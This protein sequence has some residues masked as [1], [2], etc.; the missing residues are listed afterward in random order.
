MFYSEHTYSK[1]QRG[2]SKHRQIVQIISLF[3]AVYKL[4]KGF[5]FT[6]VIWDGE[7][8]DILLYNLEG[9]ANEV[10]GEFVCSLQDCHIMHTNQ[11]LFPYTIIGKGAPI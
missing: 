5:P 8:T 3:C 7:N 2:H 11:N 1:M 9:T 6:A 4:Y 10:G